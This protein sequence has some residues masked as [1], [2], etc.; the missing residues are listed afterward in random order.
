MTTFPKLLWAHLVVEF[1]LG[2]RLALLR[3]GPWDAADGSTGAGVHACKTMVT[4]IHSL[5]LKAHQ[6]L[7]C[8]TPEPPI[9]PQVT[10]PTPLPLA[11][12]PGLE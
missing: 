10:V 7:P 11:M 5:I 2:A 12:V 9:P 6:V 4:G 1:P 8:P 3:F